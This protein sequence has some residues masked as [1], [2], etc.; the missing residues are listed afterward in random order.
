MAHNLVCRDLIHHITDG[1]EA[2][3]HR[4]D[5]LSFTTRGNLVFYT[6][7][8]QKEEEITTLRLLGD[9]LEDVNAV[10]TDSFHDGGK[11]IP[12]NY[13]TVCDTFRFNG[14][15]HLGKPLTDILGGKR[16]SHGFVKGLFEFHVGLDVIV[17]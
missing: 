17:F 14:V 16:N 4:L 13:Q 6:V 5:I 9:I 3:I 12:E 11:L 8:N 15:F 7:G 2:V 1:V 10:A